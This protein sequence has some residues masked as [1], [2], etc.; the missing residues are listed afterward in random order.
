MVYFGY[1]VRA[2][3]IKE[4][5]SFNLGQ[6]ATKTVSYIALLTSLLKLKEFSILALKEG[7]IQALHQEVVN[8][9]KLDYQLK[10]HLQLLDFLTLPLTI[11]HN[12]N[13]YLRISKP[14]PI[15]MRSTAP[16]H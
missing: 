15:Q 2:K 8:L 9:G 11:L 7:V 10:A 13:L 14:K 1:Y 4:L 3:V 5:L 16:E 12:V 6:N